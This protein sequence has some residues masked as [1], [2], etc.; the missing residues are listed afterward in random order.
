MKS[1]KEVQAVYEK[2]VRVAASY[3]KCGVRPVYRAYLE[4]ACDLGY[5][6]DIDRDDTVE[7][8]KIHAEDSVLCDLDDVD[9]A[10][11]DPSKTYYVCES[12]SYDNWPNEDYSSELGNKPYHTIHDVTLVNGFTD[13]EAVANKYCIMLEKD[14][15]Y[16]STGSGTNANYWECTGEELIA[17]L[18]KGEFAYN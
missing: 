17:F 5:L 8:V 3:A 18:K 12:S 4:S 1:E 7:K 14:N 16:S 6:L 15:D 2:A 9:Y 10:L 13:S 11:I